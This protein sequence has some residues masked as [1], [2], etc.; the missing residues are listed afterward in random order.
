M[1]EIPASDIE[2]VPSFGTQIRADFIA[3]MGKT[4]SAGQGDERFVIL[5]AIDNVLS[6]DELAVIEQVSGS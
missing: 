4:A 2:P 5:L 6:M 3:G 1:L